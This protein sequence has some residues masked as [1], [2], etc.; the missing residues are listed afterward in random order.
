MGLGETAMRCDY[1]SLFD[2][3]GVCEMNT[4]FVRMPVGYLGALFCVAP[5]PIGCFGCFWG[6]GGSAGVEEG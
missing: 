1:Y 3:M 5:G 6:G 4:E 2:E